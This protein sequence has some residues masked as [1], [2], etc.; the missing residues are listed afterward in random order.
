MFFELPDRSVKT[1]RGLAAAY[2]PVVDGAM[3]V[4]PALKILG[5]GTLTG[6]PLNLPSN[7]LELIDKNCNFVKDTLF[8]CQ[9]S[10]IK[11]THLR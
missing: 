6:R 11:R 7:T 10:G 5:M 3:T 8:F 1:K 2:E 9:I 4:I